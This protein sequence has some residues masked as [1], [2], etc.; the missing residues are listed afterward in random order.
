L[1]FQDQNG[2]KYVLLFG[3]DI[4]HGRFLAVLPD[5]PFAEGEYGDFKKI[6]LK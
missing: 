1:Y 4:D 5:Y 6:E 3:E 2:L